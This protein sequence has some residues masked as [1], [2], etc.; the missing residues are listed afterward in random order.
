MFNAK[1]KEEFINSYTRSEEITK[2][3]RNV[4]EK[5]GEFEEK[6]GSDV[7][8][9]TNE[10]ELKEILQSIVTGNRSYNS[11]KKVLMIKDYVD[12]CSL[13]FDG[14]S[15]KINEI[16]LDDIYV[17]YVK[18]H[19][20]SDPDDMKSYLDSFLC[21][22]EDL[23]MDIVYKCSLW[24]AFA[25]ISEYD[26]LNIKVK[27]VDL[28][29]AGDDFYINYNDR[30]YPVPSAAHGTFKKCVELTFFNYK[31]NLGVV[32]QK[33][34]INND[35]LLR[36]IKASGSD[37]RSFTLPISKKAKDNNMKRRINYTH[38]TWS[39]FFYRIYRAEK[40]NAIDFQAEAKRFFGNKEYKLDKSRSTQNTIWNKRTR[41]I[42]NDYTLWKKAFKKV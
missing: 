19:M 18:L 15:K 4:F 5:I 12:W 1:Q 20:A 37:F 26:I 24:M 39:G 38:A 11:D 9:I 31:Y 35:V 8:F 16:C 33:T 40:Y 27:D 30:E 7:C 29:I 32:R 14:V 42:E 25:G 2:R 3:T 36:G 34:R 10:E 13:R 21:S 22:D 28:Q 41:D 6:F 17:E 23:T